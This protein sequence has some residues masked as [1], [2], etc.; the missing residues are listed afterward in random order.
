MK[1]LTAG[2]RGELNPNFTPLVTDVAI[3]GTTNDRASAAAAFGQG[4]TCSRCKA[5]RVVGALLALDARAG[6]WR[7]DCVW[8]VPFVD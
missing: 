3:M 2:F 1:H 4:L 8:I 5:V 7:S 6:S